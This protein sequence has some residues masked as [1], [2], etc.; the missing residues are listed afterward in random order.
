M[1]YNDSLLGFGFATDLYKGNTVGWKVMLLLNDFLP[2]FL[3]AA[4]MN[5]RENKK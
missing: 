2:S 5:N 3:S 4:V 1:K